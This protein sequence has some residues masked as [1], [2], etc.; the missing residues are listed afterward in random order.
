MSYDPDSRITLSFDPPRD[1][2]FEGPRSDILFEGVMA[3]RVVAFLLDLVAIAIL[4]VVASVPF[5]ILG[6]LT[7]GLLFFVYGLYLAGVALLYITLSLGGDRGATPGMR[8]MD[9]EL[10]T[11]DGRYPGHSL[12]FIHGFL[13]FF[14]GSVTSWLI[15]LVGLFNR[16]GRLVHDFLCGTVMVNNE[17]RTISLARR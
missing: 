17:E 13:F 11:L 7:L 16:R 10:R 9:I 8:A 14:L 12:A 5:F 4:C 6:I 2:A 3:R 1:A 15:V